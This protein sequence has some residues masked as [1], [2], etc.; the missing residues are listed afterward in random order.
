LTRAH[1][2]PQFPDLVARMSQRDHLD[3]V[4]KP[5]MPVAHFLTN[6]QNDGASGPSMVN[7]RRQL[8]AYVGW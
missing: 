2:D 5:A 8:Q 7:Q 4:R 1:P 6:S 3:V